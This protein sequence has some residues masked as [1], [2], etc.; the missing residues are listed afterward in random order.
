MRP[1]VKYRTN[2][3]EVPTT[4]TGSGGERTS[5]GNTFA[6]DKLTS[7]KSNAPKRLRCNTGKHKSALVDLRPRATPDALKVLLVRNL[8][9]DSF[10][11]VAIFVQFES[12]LARPARDS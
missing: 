4:N 6:S 8:C 2:A 1:R 3:P 5:L 9:V 10:C 7:D 11:R 12:S